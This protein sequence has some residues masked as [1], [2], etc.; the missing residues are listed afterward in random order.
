M[1]ADPAGRAVS[2]RGSGEVL[3]YGYADVTS[4]DRDRLSPHVRRQL[5]E[6]VHGNETWYST[7]AKELS[8]GG[9]ACLYLRGTP[10]QRCSCAIYETRPEICSDFRIGSRRCHEARAALNT[11]LQEMESDAPSP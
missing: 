11:H 6:T 9:A 7:Q 4:K 2:T 1:D 5:L 3:A 10:G 8:M